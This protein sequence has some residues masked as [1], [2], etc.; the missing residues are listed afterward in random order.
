[1]RLAELVQVSADLAATSARNEKIALLS[2][3]LR[4]L[5]AAEIPIAVAYLSGHL[6]QGRIGLGWAALS[7]AAD[8]APLPAQS[9]LFEEVEAKPDEPLTLAQV[10]QAFE[11]ISRVSGGGSQGTRTRLLRSIFRRGSAEERDFLSRLVMGELRQGALGGIMVEAVSRASQTPIGEVRRAAMV[12][13]DLEAVAVAALQQGA[14]ALDRFGL[15]V[16]QPVL[17]MLVLLIVHET[18]TST[19]EYRG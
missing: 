3:L 14:G 17:P 10:D 12:S 19:C 16:F 7:S 1:M 18:C 15:R 4:R 2:D 8:D 6:R 9:S 13:G 11:Q 5:E